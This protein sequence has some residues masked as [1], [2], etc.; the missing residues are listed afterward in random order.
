M[1]VSF[2]VINRLQRQIL[3]LKRVPSVHCGR[4][5]SQ[6]P[7][8]NQNNGSGPTE[9][10]HSNSQKKMSGWQIHEYGG[11]EILQCSNNI[12]IPAITNPSDVLVE[13]HAASINPIDVLMMG[14][15]FPLYHNTM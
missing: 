10:G 5:Y 13:V 1:K 14:I 8:V 2:G 12:K 9:T 6:N 15:N 3:S 4:F 11:V 7:N